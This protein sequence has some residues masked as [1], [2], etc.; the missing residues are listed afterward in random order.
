LISEQ[1]LNTEGKSN[2]VTEESPQIKKEEG[3][4]KERDKRFSSLK[5][6]Q[7]EEGFPDL[8]EEK[9]KRKE[10]A[11]IKGELKKGE[12]RFRKTKGYQFRLKGRLLEVA[13]QSLRKRK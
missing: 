1:E 12:K 3:E 13:K 5:M 2:K 6:E 9:R 4:K 10:E 7:G 11:S 8:V